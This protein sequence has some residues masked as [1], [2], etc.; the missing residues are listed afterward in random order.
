MVK[1]KTLIEFEPAGVH[2]CPFFAHI[3]NLRQEISG[4]SGL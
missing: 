3:N 4:L 1:A 2:G